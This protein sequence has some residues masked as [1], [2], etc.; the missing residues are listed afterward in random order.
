MLRA[1][2]HSVLI[3]VSYDGA[4]C[5]LM[6]AIHAWRS[7]NA[8]AAY[9]AKHP[10]G[11]LIVAL[12]GTD[13]NTFLK[14]EPETTLRSM[15]AADA[16][17]C[18]HSLIEDCL[19]IDL[20]S[21]LHL[22]NQSA[23]PLPGP[24]APRKQTFGACVIGHLR[25]EKD[26]FRAAQAARLMPAE[27]E[28]RVIHLGK[29]HTQTWAHDAKLEMEQNLRYIWKG[30]VA[31]WQVRQEFAKTHVM[32]ISSNQEGGANVV[33]E[34]IVA[35][36][37]IIASNISGNVGLLGADYPGYYPVRDERALADIL[38]RVERE[39]KFLESLQCCIEKLRP[40][41][42]PKRE[43]KS[44]HTA[45]QHAAKRATKSA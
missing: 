16:L 29:A 40:Q 10:K 21:K 1:Q 7:A 31:T 39:P 6:I 5:D 30:E 28:L 24:R 45:I 32:V 4:P 17:I 44:L 19:P 9:R 42:T 25:Q 2:G 8:I 15:Y 18:L 13:V 41:F 11:A 27:S 23:T 37:P 20:R 14:T 33:S 34:A 35:G 22:V 36:V 12:G 43:A 26:P 38:W 3:D